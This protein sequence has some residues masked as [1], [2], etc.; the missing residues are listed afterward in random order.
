MS[1]Y[2]NLRGVATQLLTEFKQ[3]VISLVTITP[4]TG[5]AHNPGPSTSATKVIP[6]AV[7]RGVSFKYVNSGLAVASDLQV[8]MSVETVTPTMNDFID[9]DGSRYKIVQII[10][11][12]AAGIPVACSV[13]IRKG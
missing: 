12:P 1:I 9:I 2:D 6:G 4:G 7:A 11:K 13:I 8:N 10:N 3:G 5:P